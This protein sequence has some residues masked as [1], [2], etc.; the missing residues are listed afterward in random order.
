MTRFT[1]AYYSALAVAG[2]FIAYGL[3]AFIHD[4]C[5][6]LEDAAEHAYGTPKIKKG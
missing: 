6:F 5:N 1:I 4:L 2:A 3:V